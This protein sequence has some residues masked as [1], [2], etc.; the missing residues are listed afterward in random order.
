MKKIIDIHDVSK[1]YGKIA[2]IKNV[3]LSVNEGEIFGY[4]GPNG[5]GKT[6]T[7]R[8]L[9]GLLFPDTG[10]IEIFG[11]D[12]SCDLKF[13]LGKTGYLPGEFSLYE[14]LYV[15]QYLEFFSNL[16]GKNDNTTILTLAE[17]FQLDLSRK[18]SSL[19][20]GNK[21]KAG[22]IQALMGDPE[23]IIFDEPT[24]GLD[25]IMR[26][27]FYSLLRELKEKGKTILL[28]SHVLSEVGK[29]CDKAGI[30]RDGEI[31]AVED[32]AALGHKTFKKI[33]LYSRRKIDMSTLKK[34]ETVYDI[35]VSENHLKC[36]I[37]GDLDPLI[38]AV[39]KFGI[40]DLFTEHPDLE[41]Y[42]MDLYN[43]E[44]NV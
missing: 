8:L 35:N 31:V 21:Q 34:V 13:V 11:R 43:G 28:S 22:I 41:D 15:H 16:D 40:I 24:R 17:R 1:Y 9:L 37:K 38:K 12:I 27:K 18:I 25:P 4:L 14:N 23:L 2:G 6:T 42:F 39:Q 29:V 32:I 26:Q 5:A 19:S 10:L 44:G 30:I 20:T 3:S 7:I 33:D 36:K